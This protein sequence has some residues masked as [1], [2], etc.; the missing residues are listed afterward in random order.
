MAGSRP[1]G[2]DAQTGRFTSRQLQILRLLAGHRRLT[3]ADLAVRLEVSEESIR[4]DVRPLS[5]EGMV[6]KLH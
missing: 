6:R 1:F 2:T 5:A 3:V 4:R